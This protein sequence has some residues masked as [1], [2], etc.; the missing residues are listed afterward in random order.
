MKIPLA[1]DVDFEPDLR[2]VKRERRGVGRF[3]FLRGWLDDFFLPFAL[4][5]RQFGRG[6]GSGYLKDYTL[7]SRSFGALPDERDL[8]LSILRLGWR[9]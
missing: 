1:F 8:D 2:L 9:L 4:Y 7:G 3:V 5:F 6:R